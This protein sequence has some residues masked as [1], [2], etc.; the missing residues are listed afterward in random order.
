MKILEFPVR[1]HQFT[2]LFFLMLVALGL[3][4]WRTI[5]RAEDPPLDFPSFTVIAVY[6][7]AGPRDLERLVVREVEERL[8]GLDRVESIE[9]SIEDGVA[10]V[11]IQFEANED[12]DE[13]YDEVLRE[14]NALRPELPPELVSFT[15]EDQT[16]LNVAIA[17]LALVSETA[18]YSQLDEIAEDLEDRIAAVPGVREAERWGIPERR[19]DVELD[20]GRLAE[21]RLP[22]THVLQAIASESS[23]V[24]AGRVDAGSRSFNVRASGSYESLDEVANTV[25]RANDGQLVRIRDLADVRWGYADS[26][27]RARYDGRRAAF[28]TVMQ[29]EGWNVAVV[30]DAVWKELDAVE[31]T[32]PAG[33][34]LERGFDQ[35]ENVSHRLSR[36]GEDFLIAIA[37]VA[38][39]LLP[40][41]LRAAGIVMVSIPLSLAIGVT[42]LN[43]TGYTLNQLSIV[44]AVIA[45][46]LLVDDSIVVV[47]NI[48]RFLR[49]GRTRREAAVEAT[50]QIAVAVLGATA[51]LVFAFVPLLFLPGNSGQFIRSLPLA[52]VYTVLASLLVSLTIIP[53]LSSMMLKDGQPEGGSRIFRIFERGIH[54]TYAP[55]LD[56]ALGR[57]KTTLAL[58]AAFVVAGVAL[59]P[60]VGFSLFPK[61]ET[62][63]FIVNIT[64][65][66][67]ASIDA[68]DDAARYAERVLES[69]PEVRAVFTSVGRDNPMVYYNVIPRRENPAT[70]QLFVLLDEY[71]PERTPGLLDELRTELGEYPAA[72]LEVIE[73]ENGPPI[74]A[75]IAMRIEGPDLDTLRVLAEEVESRVASVSGTQYVNNPVRLQRTDL[76]VHVD[77][78]KAGLLG[79]PTV[80]VDRTLRLGLEG[81]EAGVLREASGEA[82]DIVVRVARE[83]R[84]TPDVFDRV[85]VASVANVL[86]PL[87]Q[88]ADVRLE[89]EVPEIE[90]VDRQRSVT[91][92]SFVRTGYVTDR[93]TRDV[94]AQL[95]Q[96]DLPTGYE[97]VAAGEIESRQ[98]SFGGIG[99]AVIVAIFMIFA[100]LVLEFG[101]FRSMLIVAS[102][103]PL[104]VVGGIATL[105]LVGQT[106]SFTA[107]I[108]FVA[109]VGIEIKTSIL[110]VDFTNHLRREGVGLEDAIRQAGEVRFIPIL[111]T[112]MTAVGGLLPLALQGQALYAPLAW[113]IIGG[114][115]ASTFLGRIVTPVLY[116][117]L[118]PSMEAAA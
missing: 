95:D 104:G 9:S 37:L 101:T 106:L 73:F 66:E 72:R 41:G 65:A 54:R 28:L 51:T 63:Q 16:T 4:S 70:G 97:I 60:A 105:F 61:A 5:P 115:L 77:R 7:G 98:E 26:T 40:L 17:Q 35:A 117:L 44:G 113:V 12:P 47:E 92:T 6:P 43:L 112:A 55:V 36:L 74:D 24:P 116:K 21:L 30:R 19:V 109:L 62:P 90:R 52:V 39:T 91:V 96:V 80:E 42:L 75:P 50:K 118:P 114:L 3:S 1:N 8:D 82:R 56:W 102:V 33:I 25:V 108:G 15:V 100:I 81:L 27:Y 49:E 20:L 94:L 29:Q 84:P 34:T 46:G 85:Y 87:R 57:P 38:V 48:T 78:D 14:M 31:A 2:V 45:L 67:G 18:P 53:W 10:V 58:A 23:D 88:I 111:L 93:V 68:T 86:T 59:V 110:L 22:P 32:L 103:I 107:M 89:T 99:S 69:R 71:D 13:K 79:V 11:F 64:A 83:E 76:R